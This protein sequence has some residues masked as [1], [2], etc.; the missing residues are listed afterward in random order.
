MSEL[1]QPI[2]GMNDILP[3][4][5]PRWQQLES[6]TRAVLTAYGYR[7]MRVPIVEKTE[8]FARSIG[9]VTDIVEKEMY[10]FED[11]N[12]EHL[13]LR[14]EATAGMVRAGLSNGLLYNQV[15]RLWCLGPMFRHERPQKGRYRQFHQ[16]DVE[17]YGLAGPDIDAE[18]NIMLA[19]LWKVLGV[20]AL[21]LQIN[22]LGTS[23][24]RKEYRKLLLEYFRRHLDALD[25]DSRRRLETNPLRILDSKV[26]E[27]RA[28]V[29][30]A[31]NLL[32]HLDAESAAHFAGFKKFLDDA[33]IRY[34]VNP[35]LVRGL[36][37]YTRTVFEWVTTRLGAQDAVCSGGR[38][39]GLVEHLGGK[40]TP[41]IGFAMGM[42][43]LVALMEDVQVPLPD[44]SPHAYLVRVGAEAERAGFKLAEQL[45]SAL[46]GLRLLTDCSG[47]D[48]GKQLKRADKSGARVAL[49]LGD[50]EARN[51][52]VGFKPLRNTTEQVNISWE[53]AAARLAAW[54]E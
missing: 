7:E 28:V 30:G 49:V 27:T 51:Q 50:N 45:R 37:Y 5:T 39:D 8:L 10:S 3:D 19:R 53:Q 34:R 16:V 4:A 42:E 40:P 52:Q 17:A 41:A 1:I 38:Y 44:S 36:D 23:A 47:G 22:T 26:P 54:L 46:P 20:E 2:R 13:T 12:G 6:V 25:A 24:S 32:E 35:R 29:E 21:E 18:L 43:R 15:Q 9:E 48:F 11:R 14:P 33:G 31:P